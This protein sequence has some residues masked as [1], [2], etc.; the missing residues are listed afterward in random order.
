MNTHFIHMLHECVN[1][2]CGVAPIS[3]SISVPSSRISP[4]QI[5]FKINFMAII[6]SISL[7]LFLSGSLRSFTRLWPH[8]LAF[9]LFNNSSLSLFPVPHQ[10]E[11]QRATPSPKISDT[12][13]NPFHITHKPFTLSLTC[14]PEKDIKQ[15]KDYTWCCAQMTSALQ[16]KS[17]FLLFFFSLFFRTIIYA[18]L[19]FILSSFPGYKAFSPGCDLKHENCTFFGSR[20]LISIHY[21]KIF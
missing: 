18:F 10:H 21:N 8:K 17:I 9:C 2:T 20:N 3:Q 6:L 16:I 4:P 5:E 12:N 1:L 19:T 13:L 15:T 7:S 11:S 14:T